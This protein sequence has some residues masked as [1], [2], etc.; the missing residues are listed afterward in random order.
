MTMD[1]TFMVKMKLI[2]QK[3]FG[4]VTYERSGMDAS[5]GQAVN[6]VSYMLKL[7]LSF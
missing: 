6:P 1:L 4:I 5:L 2:G 7:H 3:V